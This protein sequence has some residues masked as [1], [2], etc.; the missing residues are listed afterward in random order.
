[1]SAMTWPPT[2]TTTQRTNPVMT[3]GALAGLSYGTRAFG[4]HRTVA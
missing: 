4:V 1:M 3:A 2:L